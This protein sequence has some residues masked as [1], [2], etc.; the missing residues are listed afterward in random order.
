MW[1][2]VVGPASGG[3][4]VGLTEATSRRYIARLTEPSE[5]SFNI[6]GRG[7]QAPLI[8]ELAS[9]I[10][11]M[12]QPG[13]PGEPPTGPGQQLFRGRVGA[14]ADDIT[15]TEHG[16][17]VTALDYRAVLK[18]RRTI[19]TDTNVLAGI[20]QAEIAW[21]LI[22]QTQSHLAGDL[23]ISKGVG[24][25]G[26]SVVRD[27]TYMAGDSI[28]ERI[29]ELS[30]VVDGFDWDITPVSPSALH[31]DVWFP[32]RGGN[33]GVVLELGGLVS[34]ANRDVDPGEYANA[35]RV[36]GDDGAAAPPTPVERDVIDP[37]TRPEGRWDAVFGESTIQTQ[38][39]LN[40]R[41]DWLR[42][43]SQ[44]IRPAYS[45]TL[46]AGGWGGP[47][48]IWLGDT[49]QVVINSGRLAVNTALRVY[50]LQFDISADG[51][52]TVTVTAGRPRPD[53]RKRPAQFERRITNLERR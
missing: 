47:G 45:L 34:K 7:V 4:D 16:M 15:E 9:D 12:W 21:T 44:V 17:Q 20:D 1:T 40:A 28:G 11:V 35:I 2:F 48:H 24:F 51:G 37:D 14:T 18:R 3:H 25:P 23:G 8:E 49:V 13:A 10:H 38:A 46:K 50:E 30:E 29:Q 32:Q 22:A 6:D 31:L 41:A 27:R 33:K 5:V 53:Y 36:T 19:N 39:A 42:E 52:E 26:A 43:E